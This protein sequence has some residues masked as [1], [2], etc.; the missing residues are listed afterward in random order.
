MAAMFSEEK[1]NSLPIRSVGG[2]AIESPNQYNNDYDN[3]PKFESISAKT[4]DPTP[5]TE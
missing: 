3:N 1:G 2:F 5:E 4:K